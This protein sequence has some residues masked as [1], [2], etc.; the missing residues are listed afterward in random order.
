MKLLLDLFTQYG[1]LSVWIFLWA[2][3]PQIRQNYR[4]KIYFSGPRSTWIIFA[5]GYILFGV[6]ILLNGDRLV[7]FEE[8]VGLTECGV[9]IVQSVIYPHAK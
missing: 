2:V 3:L 8:L 1:G 7:A 6:Y 5:V 9:I 4:S